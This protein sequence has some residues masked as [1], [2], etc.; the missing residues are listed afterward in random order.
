MGFVDKTA[1]LLNGQFEIK[2]LDVVCDLY[3]MS[4]WSN[5]LPPKYN[6]ASGL[7]KTGQNRPDCETIG[8]QNITGRQLNSRPFLYV[9]GLGLLK[10]TKSAYIY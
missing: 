10:N 5:L 2:G 1:T 3:V 9:E 7:S 6:K 8:P 4:R